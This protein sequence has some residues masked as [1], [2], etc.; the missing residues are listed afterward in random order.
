MWTFW[1]SLLFSNLSFSLGKSEPESLLPIHSQFQNAQDQ[2]LHNMDNQETSQ[3]S[4]PLTA[5]YH[6]TRQSTGW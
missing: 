1:S 4:S 6:Q 2:I 3:L 5:P